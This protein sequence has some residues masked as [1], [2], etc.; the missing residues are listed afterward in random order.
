MNR[1]EQLYQKNVPDWFKEF[2]RLS[3]NFFDIRNHVTTGESNTEEKKK[4]SD[5]I[6]RISYGKDNN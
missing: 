6:E 4:D 5:S 3:D 1:T 2:K